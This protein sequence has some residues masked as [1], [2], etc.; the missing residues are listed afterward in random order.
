MFPG[1]EL[2]WEVGEGNALATAISQMFE[3]FGG[4]SNYKDNGIRVLL[5]H[6]TKTMKG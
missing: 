6:W 5:M 3:R 4:S 1:D 2:K